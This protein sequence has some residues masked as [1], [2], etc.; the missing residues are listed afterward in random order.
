MNE[1]GLKFDPRKDSIKSIISSHDNNNTTM[2]FN[3]PSLNRKDLMDIS[4]I[5]TKSSQFKK[6]Y[7][8]RDWSMNL[9]NLDIEGSCPRRFSYFTNKEDFI[10]KNNDIEKSSP[11]SIYSSFTYKSPF[12]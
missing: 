9:Y 7:T 2:D 4:Q 1:N 3:Y 6:L 11:K 8:N 12:A 10:N 5:N